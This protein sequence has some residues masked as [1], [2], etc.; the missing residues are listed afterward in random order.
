MYAEQDYP[1]LKKTA[2]SIYLMGDLFEQLH[3]ENLLAMEAIHPAYSYFEEQAQK[4]TKEVIGEQEVND[5]ATEVGRIKEKGVYPY[6]GEPEDAVTKAKR[7]VFDILAVEV[8]RVVPRLKTSHRQTKKLTYRLMREAINTN[9]SSIKTILTEVFTLTQKQQDDLAELLTHT[10]LPEIIDVAKTVSDRLTFIQ[11]LEQMVYNDVLG[12]PIKERT[13]FYKFLLKELWIFGEKYTL[14][15]SDQSLKNLLKAHISRLGRDELIPNIPPEAVEDL[16][17]IPDICL[18]EQICP[19][20]E[21]YEHLVIEP[22]RPTLTLTLKELDQIRDHALAVARNPL[23]DKLCTKWHF[24][25]LGQSLGDDVRHALENQVVGDGNYYNAGN[26][27]ISIF[28]WS[29]SFKTTS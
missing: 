24:I 9:P 12:K 7:E 20:Y 29:K 16:T 27:S 25:L 8:N 13:Q 28:E 10:H 22:K 5:A 26:I 17:R 2:T 19:G 6:Q 18:F 15:T 21:I 11:M 23:F 3:R 4:F 14:G 1:S